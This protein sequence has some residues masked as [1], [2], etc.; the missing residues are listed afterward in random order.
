MGRISLVVVLLVAACGT[1][2]IGRASAENAAAEDIDPA[3]LMREI[4][5]LQQEIDGYKADLEATQDEAGDLESDLENN[6]KEQNDLIKKIRKI[7]VDLETSRVDLRNL[8]QRHADLERSRDEQTHFLTQQIRAAYSLGNQEYV[9]VL[10]NQQDP[11]DIARMLAYYDYLNAA[12]A[13][14]IARYRQTLVELDV[15]SKNIE[16]RSLALVDLRSDLE[17]E[18]QLLLERRAD[19]EATLARLQ[20]SIADTGTAIAR[21]M[22]D[23][24]ELEALLQRLNDGFGGLGTSDAPFETLRGAL[25]MPVDGRVVNRFGTRRNTGQ[26]RWNGIFIAAEAGDPV[27]AIHYGRVV[28]SDWLRGFG[29]LLIISHGE[30]YMSLYGHNE[31]LL[32]ETGEWVTAGETVAA[33]GRSG[34]ADRDGLYFE[35]RSAGKPTDPQLWCRVEGGSGL[36]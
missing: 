20:Q 1:A 22:R 27:R 13:D 14:Q 18:H 10:L 15:V 7:E 31:V 33:V 4:Q 35:I 2:W 16:E 26:L 21:R 8:Q 11:S 23:R 34:A 32:R 24:D 36:G 17:V 19:R 12:R 6:E 9:K 29:L 5:A 3:Q 25:P 30:G 28:F